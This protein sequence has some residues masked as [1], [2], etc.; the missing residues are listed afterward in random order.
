MG[1]DILTEG[2][3]SR[4]AAGLDLL[5]PHRCKDSG[6]PAETRDDARHLLEAAEEAGR[7]I[8]VH[9]QEP[10]RRDYSRGW[11]PIAMVAI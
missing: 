8:P 1:G 3:A 11:E 5:C 9:Y 7:A 2:V 6:S 4:I 10:F